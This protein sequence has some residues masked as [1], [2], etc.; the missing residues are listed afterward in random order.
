[1]YGPPGNPVAVGATSAI[2]VTGRASEY[3]W[4][5]AEGARARQHAAR[6]RD[7]NQGDLLRRHS[8]GSQ[9]DLSRKEFLCGSVA[10]VTI[11]VMHGPSSAPPPPPSSSLPGGA[12]AAFMVVVAVVVVVVVVVVVEV[13][14]VAVIP[15]L[16]PPCRHRFVS[17]SPS[18]RSRCAG[19]AWPRRTW[20]SNA[21]ASPGASRCR[22]RGRPNARSPPRERRRARPPCRANP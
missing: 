16:P 1:M 21:R 3:A 8:V 9:G 19:R 10:G 17:S 4:R 22:W 14:V 20:P 7:C 18:K 12:A 15:A 2:H 6:R 11:V 13:V 5:I